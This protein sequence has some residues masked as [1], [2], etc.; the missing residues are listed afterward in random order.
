[1]WF[2]VCVW[3]LGER[4]TY[5]FG[6]TW[7]WVND[8]RI[9]IFGLTIPVITIMSLPSAGKPMSFFK[10]LRGPAVAFLRSKHSIP[11]SSWVR[12]RPKMHCVLYRPEF[13]PLVHS[14]GAEVTAQST[15]IIHTNWLSLIHVFKANIARSGA[16]LDM[17]HWLQQR[18]VLLHSS[19][20]SNYLL[21]SLT[22]EIADWVHHRA[23]LVV[24]TQSSVSRSASA[25]TQVLLLNG[26]ASRVQGTSQSS[27][28]ARLTK[29]REGSVRMQWKER[30][31]WFEWK[32]LERSQSWACDISNLTG[33]V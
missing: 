28:R 23:S 2:F 11:A 7:G 6:T 30:P 20:P 25:K 5:G 26:E 21:I 31:V 15:G 9:F 14:C 12:Q 33:C 19:V 27:Q 22:T 18:V 32:Y 1:M 24:N 17:A 4:K 16:F 10:D 13:K 29:G 8:D 3:F